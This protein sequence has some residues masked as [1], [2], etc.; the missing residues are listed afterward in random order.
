MSEHKELPVGV[1]GGGSFGTAIA[2]L[3]AYNR[4][5]VLY[6]RN[7]KVVEQINSRQERH[8]IILPERV[9]ATTSPEEVA[10]KCRL[11]FPVVPSGAFRSMMRDLAPHLY[12]Y[13][14]M[15][16]ATKGFDVHG[17]Q[18]EDIEEN[19]ITRK[20]VNTIS[21]VIMQESVVARIGCLS[22][23]NLAKEI[24][25]GQPTATLIASK[26]D[27]VINAGKNALSSP[28]FHVFG[29]HDLLGAE[30]A[31]ALKNT[32]ALGSG[33]LKGYGLGKNIQAMLLT[34]G[35][36]E[37]VYFGKAMGSEAQAFFG[38]A[39]IGDLIATATS[40]KSR[41]Y[42]FGFRIGQ[43]ESLEEVSNTMPE[44]AEGVRT[45]R[46]TRHLAKF[47]KLRVP[48]TEMLYQIVFEGFPIQKAM[49]YL[50]TFPYDVDVDIL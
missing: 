17:M 1:I 30:L 19:G 9:K 8:G 46:I 27:E 39:G 4:D 38:T 47:Y 13:H 26:Y 12:P 6:A 18:E 45:L 5:V 24:L 37:M 11:L 43:G 41:N 29:S 34:R 36:M 21:E 25:E 42:T 33:L 23:P 48:I 20:Y 3:L 28:L 40:K 2:N 15:I 14:L 49:D 22:G 31:G 50:M 35:L 10:D 16:H 7:A 44:L 32:I